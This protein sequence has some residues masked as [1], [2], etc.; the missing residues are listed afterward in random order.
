MAFIRN[1]EVPKNATV[2]TQQINTDL[3][4]AEE[5]GVPPP[6]RNEDLIATRLS[7]HRFINELWLRLA[8]RA[9]IEVEGV[10]YLKRIPHLQPL[11]NDEGA[12]HIIHAISSVVNPT[13][14]LA[15]ISDA[16]YIEL[17]DGLEKSLAELIVDRGEDFGI[18]RTS[19]MK[20]LTASLSPLIRG[21]LSRAVN[22]FEATN[23]ITTIT[24]QRAQS[25]IKESITSS[26]GGLRIRGAN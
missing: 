6:P 24:E 16:E 1:D 21:Q 15:K 7:S 2:S 5:A 8:G 9:Y 14:T 22:G 12:M 19:A 20:L 26:G 25:D 18:K 3:I 13:V 17:A 11:V 4:L 23:L 10:G